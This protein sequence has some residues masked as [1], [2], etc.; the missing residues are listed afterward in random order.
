MY[1]RGR[2]SHTGDMAYPMSALKQV[3]EFLRKRPGEPWCTD[4]LERALNRGIHAAPVLLE[5]Y[6]RFRRQHTSCVAC[7]LVR[8]TVRYTE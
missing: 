7:G 3:Q 5:G 8:L 4:C 1:R 6:P 2:S